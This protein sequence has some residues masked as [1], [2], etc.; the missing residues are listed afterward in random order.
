[1]RS[2]P[3]RA[4]CTVCHSSPSAVIGLKKRWKS[5][6]KAVSVPS[7]IS[8]AAKTRPVPAQSSSAVASAASVAIAGG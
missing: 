6:T 3:D 2:A 8:Q 5:R 4:L 7:E 1:M